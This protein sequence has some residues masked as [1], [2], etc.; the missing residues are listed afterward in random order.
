MNVYLGLGNLF[1]IHTEKELSKGYADIVME[2]FLAR[3]NDIKYSYLLEIKYLKSGS[4]TDKK[5]VRQLESQAVKQ[6][7][8]Y[9]FDKKLEKKFENTAMIRL[10]L[11]FSGSDLISIG[12]A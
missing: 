8:N 9:S 6:L 11:V 2:P 7:L 4:K 10:F 3:Y 5:A 1:I 12:T